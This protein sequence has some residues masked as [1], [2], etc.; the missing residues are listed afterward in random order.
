MSDPGAVPGGPHRR[1][2]V[3]VLIRT[4]GGGQGGAESVALELLR[5]LD[6]ERFDPTLCIARRP[7]PDNTASLELIDRLRDEEGI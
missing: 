5:S 3:L 2:R 1:L 7:E 4:T 6:R